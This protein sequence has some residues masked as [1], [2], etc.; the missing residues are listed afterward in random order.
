[1]THGVTTKC[2]SLSHSL[3]LSLCLCR[4]PSGYPYS[5]LYSQ[6]PPA[7][8]SYY[9]APPSSESDVSESVGAQP[10]SVAMGTGGG[11]YLLQGNYVLAGGGG[12][13]GGGQGYGNPNS[14][15]PPATVSVHDGSPARM[16]C[17]LKAGAGT[18]LWV[19]GNS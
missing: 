8:S 1:M 15:A 13:V 9:D 6:T 10:V 17:P 2:I 3:T 14:R 4:R 12:G 11:G 18:V 5:P 16:T 19:G 7:S